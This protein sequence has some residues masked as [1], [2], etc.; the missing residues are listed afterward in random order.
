MARGPARS[1]EPLIL[2]KTRFLHANRKPT[3]LENAF[4]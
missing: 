2:G 1:A 4:A 3:S